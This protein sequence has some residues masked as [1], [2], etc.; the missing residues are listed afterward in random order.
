MNAIWS[1]NGVA[2][3]TYGLTVIGGQ[4]LSG[5]ASSVRL[6]AALNADLAGDFSDGD[7]VSIGR[8]GSLFFSGKVRQLDKAAD[9]KSEGHDYLVEDAWADLEKTTYQEP[10]HYA[11]GGT[12]LLPVCVLGMNSSG[13][14]MSVSEQITAVLA[15]AASAGISIQSG[16]FPTGMD[17]WPSEAHSI[18]C[19]EI[20]R[21]CLRYHPDWISWIDHTTS[22]PTFN[23]KTRAAAT[24]VSIG[25]TDCANVKIGK[26]ADRIPACVRIC[27]TCSSTID[28]VVY[29]NYVIDKYPAGGPDSGPGVLCTDIE[30]AGGQAAIA[31]QQV[32]TYPIPF[33]GSNSSAPND[34]TTYQAAAKT[35][36]KWKFPKLVHIAA[37]APNGIIEQG[38]L[39]T[40]FSVIKFGKALVVDGNDKPVAINPHAT[41]LQLR[42][43]LDAPRELVQGPLPEWIRKRSGMVQLR[44]LVKPT[45]TATQRELDLLKMLPADG[46]LPPIIGTNAETKIYKGQPQWKTTSDTVPTGLAQAYYQ[47]IQNSSLLDGSVTL[48]GT[49]AASYHGCT[50]SV[51]G[52]D[53]EWA[54]MLAPIHS[55]SWQAQNETVEV[56]FGPNPLLGI[57]DF[58]EYLRLLRRRGVTWWSSG[59]RA[60]AEIGSDTESSAHGDNVTGGVLP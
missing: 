8:N 48:V 33:N 40:A 10:W 17:L 14:L 22:P 59:E 25:M 29:R 45:N 47:A 51:G 32:E 46:I 15:F 21:Q 42:N 6:H 4:F 38:V 11:G 5:Q 44:L 13:T 27:F 9:D 43:D 30:L 19:A 39:D 16:T 52:G 26:R 54:T 20:I 3:S 57:T 23:I 24:P 12:V 36:L 35:Y 49:N 28:D 1:V 60:S 50:L 2:P 34:I 41:R 7:A 56:S 55:I 53:S 31:K 37:D 58:L 18:S